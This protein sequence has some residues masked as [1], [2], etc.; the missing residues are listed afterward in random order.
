MIERR[1]YL[2][3]AVVGDPVDHPFTGDETQKHAV[4]VHHGQLMEPGLA[5]EGQRLRGVRRR[6]DRRYVLV[7]FHERGDVRPLERGSLGVPEITE[8]YE[9]DE[10]IAS[11]VS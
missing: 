6:G 11:S 8:R 10:A 2:R 5:E 4:D 7:T 3:F 9:T 1:L